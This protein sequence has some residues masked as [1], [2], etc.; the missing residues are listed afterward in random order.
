MYL[1]FL[2]RPQ[3]GT[4]SAPRKL[5]LENWPRE[6]ISKTAMLRL[7]ETIRFFA[8]PDE[9]R[10]DLEV[11]LLHITASRFTLPQLDTLFVSL[12]QGVFDGPEIL[13]QLRVIDPKL[14]IS[15]LVARCALS[16]FRPE[17]LRK[18]LRPTEI[19]Y[20]TTNLLA[21]M[22]IDTEWR[23][24][25]DFQVV[26]FMLSR[27]LPSAVTP[28]VVTAAALSMH[29]DVLE[30]F[31]DHNSHVSIDPSALMAA[32]RSIYPA[33]PKVRLIL[34]RATFKDETFDTSFW[35]SFL[36]NNHHDTLEV[37]E[38]LQGMFRIS[39]NDALIVAAWRTDSDEKLIG[40]LLEDKSFVLSVNTISA[41]LLEHR[42]H[43]KPKR[44]R[45]LLDKVKGLVIDGDLV[46]DSFCRY[47]YCRSLLKEH[48]D[49]SILCVSAAKLHGI[50]YGAMHN[51]RNASFFKRSSAEHDVRESIGYYVAA[52]GR[53]TLSRTLLEM[54]LL[55]DVKLALKLWQGQTT[56]P[57]S[58]LV[59]VAVNLEPQVHDLDQLVDLL[60]DNRL[61]AIDKVMVDAFTPRKPANGDRNWR[62][63]NFW[64]IMLYYIYIGD[65]SLFE[66]VYARLENAQIPSSEIEWFFALLV[67]K[68][69]GDRFRSSWDEEGLWEEASP[70]FVEILA[71]LTGH[72]PS[73]ILGP[74]FFR[75]IKEINP[76]EQVAGTAVV[77]A[78]TTVLNCSIIIEWSL[79][80]QA[81]LYATHSAEVVTKV[82]TAIGNDFMPCER[83]ALTAINSGEALL[84]VEFLWRRFPHMVVTK[85]MVEAAVRSTSVETLDFLVARSE[86]LKVTENLIRIALESV[87]PSVN[88]TQEYY[89]S[90]RARWARRP[91]VE[92]MLAYMTDFTL[93]HSTIELA[94]CN[95]N[96][97]LAQQLQ[98]HAGV[99]GLSRGTVLAMID[100]EWPAESIY[101]ELKRDNDM[102]HLFDP[103]I[104]SKACKSD[105]G[106]ALLRLTNTAQHHHSAIQAALLA[107]AP[108]KST[109]ANWLIL[110]HLSSA[111]HI[112]LDDHELD[113]LWRQCTGNV[114]SS[115]QPLFLLLE[116]GATGRIGPKTFRS[117]V[118]KQDPSRQPR[119]PESLPNLPAD[120]TDEVVAVARND[121]YGRVWFDYLLGPDHEVTVHESALLICA[122]L[123][124]EIWLT[125]L[126]Q[127]MTPE[128]LAAVD[129]EALLEAAKA[130]AKRR[131]V[132][133]CS[134]LT[135]RPVKKGAWR[136]FLRRGEWY[137][138]SPT[139]RV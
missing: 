45:W 90:L 19:S 18:C 10:E 16:S 20:D 68:P 82:M 76:I 97:E 13:H 17:E 93:S 88:T 7:F 22:E 112:H 34:E 72:F 38:L 52:G 37:F 127:K 65:L 91:M 5:L 80:S 3:K 21:A 39:T 121:L 43:F 135:G 109:C 129:K 23:R 15:P 33:L 96:S 75:S 66:Q 89:G 60:I 138:P 44:F 32:M 123:G 115:K 95:I 104:I 108:L 71:F 54:L 136:G 64:T 98:S 114:S 8:L 124:E 46:A 118:L 84:K 4:A 31:L 59:A 126:L 139:R 30:A 61:E 26:K 48:G 9:W 92:L 49:P 53:V 133:I 122:R 2:S 14:A 79:D 56:M 131:V 86:Q 47:R 70:S 41:V 27:S 78:W 130:S 77:E 125:R 119:G 83:L 6:P 106:R 73:V 94:V 63:R 29:A 117:F 11:I 107:E 128:Q 132:E 74:K 50:L 113:H 36:N 103:D 111:P 12:L 57:L 40:R 81:L 100:R 55:F 105:H 69:G 101:H 110:D 67:T 99:D 85:P 51:D 87:D 42:H 1:D 25:P 102:N 62:F 116:H 35:V 24:L 28:E 134:A 137:F 120:I 58:D